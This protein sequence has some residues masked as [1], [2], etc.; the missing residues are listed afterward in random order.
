MIDETFEAERL[1]DAVT[2]YAGDAVRVLRYLPSGAFAATITDPPY[3]SGGF[4]RGDRMGTVATK[5]VQSG[6]ERFKGADFAGDNRDARSW[7]YWCH[8]WLSECLRVTRRGGY[9]LCFTDWRQLPL[10]T[11]AVQG[12]GWQWRGILSWDKG[13]SARAGGP[14]QF[15]IQCEYLV[16]ATAGPM[17]T[18]PAWPL[19]GEGCYPGSYSVPVVQADK[20]H[21]TGKPTRLMRDL[22]R[23][24]KPGDAVLDPFAGSGTTLVAAALEGRNATGIEQGDDWRAV[25]RQR[26]DEV[27]QRQPRTL[28]AGVTE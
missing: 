5:Y 20:W 1:S 8:L 14:N 23:C 22:M 28:F 17:V 9:L 21:P 24:V 11:D 13:P 6:S 10:L 27:Y 4:T 25:I 26:F 3:S 16:W 19:E 2:L 12:A 18:D 7:A 15:R